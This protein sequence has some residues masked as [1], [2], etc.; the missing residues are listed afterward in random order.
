VKLPSPETSIVAEEKV[1][2]YLLN[3]LHP[4]GA[5]KAQFFAALGFGTEDW[6]LFADSLRGVAARNQVTRTVESDH[7]VK[8]IVDGTIETPAGRSPWVR[9][10]WIVDHGQTVPRLVTAYPQQPEQQR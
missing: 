6:R 8:Y 9:T 2:G 5:G 4:D 7:G 10:V 1:V 3:P